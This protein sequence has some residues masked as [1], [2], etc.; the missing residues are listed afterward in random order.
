MKD[1]G[2]SRRKDKRGRKIKLEVPFNVPSH[3]KSNRIGSQTWSTDRQRK[4]DID[5]TI[6]APY[7]SRDIPDS[8]HGQMPHVE[9]TSAP[10]PHLQDDLHNILESAIGRHESKPYTPG[11]DRL[12][13]GRMDPFVRYPVELNDRTRELV[14]LGKQIMLYRWQHYH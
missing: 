4:C 8:L 10:L 12:W 7:I 11:F 9:N 13:H 3:P 1:I 14:D 5:S 2:K 6:N